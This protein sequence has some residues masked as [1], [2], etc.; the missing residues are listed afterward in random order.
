MLYEGK[1]VLAKEF[2]V[3][4]RNFIHTRAFREICILMNISHPNIISVEDIVIDDNKIYLI[5]ES[6]EC[7]ALKLFTSG[8]F[9]TEDNIVKLLSDVS[10]G[11]QYLHSQN[12][13]HCDLV[14]SNIVKCG[15]KFKIIDFGNAIKGHRFHSY[16]DPTPYIG[17]YWGASHQKIDIWALGCMAYMLYTNK[18]LFYG[19]DSDSQREEIAKRYGIDNCIEKRIGIRK[20][21]PNRDIANIISGMLRLDPKK[22]KVA[23]FNKKKYH[24]TK[25]KLN[26]IITAIK[27][28]SLKI[29]E[30]WRKELYDLLEILRI[31]C[32]YDEF[33]LMMTNVNKI[34]ACNLKDYLTNGIIFLWLSKKLSYDIG[35]HELSSWLT[36]IYDK[37]I[38]AEI[39]NNKITQLLNS[40]KWKFD[41]YGL[42]DIISNQ[43][44][45]DEISWNM[46]YEMFFPDIKRIEESNKPIDMN[47]DVLPFVEVMG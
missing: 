40:I 36:M 10:T 25:T 32:S 20:E 31:E 43:K 41:S 17:E 11:L 14:L 44:I 47:L 27:N 45:K 30:G 18:L 38:S 4:K 33:I 2:N 3:Q 39:I 19:Q 23:Y 12:I 26:T 1:V 46:I 8:Y 35:L 29:C 9:S 28:S 5:L 21:I 34:G 42:Y 15:D 22:R 24:T 6:A 13:S 7:D 37:Q 16:S